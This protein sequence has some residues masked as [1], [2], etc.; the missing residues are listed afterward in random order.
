MA[1]TA[2]YFGGWSRRKR[3]PRTLT[4]DCESTA[5]LPVSRKER[6]TV[7]EGPHLLNPPLP[8][9][10]NRAAAPSGALSPRL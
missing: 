3:Q 10:P 5:S 4:V 9:L 8:R 7:L 6:G 2:I 1:V